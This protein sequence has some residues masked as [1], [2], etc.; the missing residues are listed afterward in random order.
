MSVGRPPISPCGRLSAYHVAVT[1]RSPWNERTILLP[2]ARSISTLCG[3]LR[4]SGL[5]SVRGCMTNGMSPQGGARSPLQRASTTTGRPSSRYVQ[6]V[7]LSLRTTAAVSHGA[8]AGRSASQAERLDV[9]SSRGSAIPASRDPVAPY[10][11]RDERDCVPLV[12][13]FANT[14]QIPCLA[15][16]R[17]DGSDWAAS[18]LARR[19]FTANFR[20]QVFWS[21]I[22]TLDTRPSCRRILVCPAARRGSS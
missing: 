20:H 8:F 11:A 9:M 7:T 18:R 2:S 4:A 21:A 13:R 17:K 6:P 14:A 16:P 15:N 10:V 1:R 19:S 12:S 3:P 5:P 22:A